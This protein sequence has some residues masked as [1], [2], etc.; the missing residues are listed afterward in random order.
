MNAILQAL[1]GIFDLEGVGHVLGRL[2]LDDPEHL[3]SDRR[4]IIGV[5]VLDPLR[6][7]LDGR[8]SELERR[9]VIS[10]PDDFIVFVLVVAQASQQRSKES[11]F[12][13]FLAPARKIKALQFSQQL[14]MLVIIDSRFA[15]FVVDEV[16]S[17]TAVERSSFVYDLMITSFITTYPTSPS[18]S[19]K[20]TSGSFRRLVG[21]K[22]PNVRCSSIRV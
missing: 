9:T 15:V 1:D 13:E 11:R 6:A 5:V 14:A 18:M 8:I 17:Q 4:H 2:R 22:R 12:D 3:L 16:E 10:V 19:Q 7:F 20:P 21:V